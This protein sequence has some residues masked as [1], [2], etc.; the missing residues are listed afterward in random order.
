MQSFRVRPL[1]V[2]DFFAVEVLGAIL[3]E[4][5]AELEAGIQ[6]ERES[7][8]SFLYSVARAGDD[9]PIGTVIVRGRGDGGAHVGG[10]IRQDVEG[11]TPELEAQILS[12]VTDWMEREWP[13][14]GFDFAFVPDFRFRTDV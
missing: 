4:A 10:W 8:R 14:S 12:A 5:R 1:V 11:M 3:D 6:E 7:R 2:D 13:F 9:V